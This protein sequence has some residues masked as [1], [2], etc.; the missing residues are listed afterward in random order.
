MKKLGKIS[1]AGEWHSRNTLESGR[2]GLAKCRPICPGEA[3][4]V[5]ETETVGNFRDPV[6]MSRIGHAAI[7]P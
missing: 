6:V 3:P 1:R 4:Q 5:R 7:V 2:R